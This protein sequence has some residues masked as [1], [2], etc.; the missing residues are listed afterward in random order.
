[1]RAYTTQA[2]ICA[3]I[4]ARVCVFVGRCI[5]V[6]YVCVF[7]SVGTSMCVCSAHACALG[8]AR[9]RRTRARSD[10]RRCVRAPVMRA[11][12]V[13]MDHV[14][15]GS[16]AFQLASAFNANIDAWNTARV[17]SLYAVCAAF[18]GAAQTRSAGV[19][20]SHTY[21]CR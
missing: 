5:C 21:K 12:F 10:P 2:H 16:Q 20:C 11:L 7:A 3:L 9:V 15:F 18:G 19:R 4:C 14:W 8:P 13:G 1:M 17:T 6:P